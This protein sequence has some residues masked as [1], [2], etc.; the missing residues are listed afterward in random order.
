MHG[1]RSHFGASQPLHIPK[2][3]LLSEDDLQLQISSLRLVTWFHEDSRWKSTAGGD[4][5]Q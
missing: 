2:G 1:W 5:C 4:G 3:K